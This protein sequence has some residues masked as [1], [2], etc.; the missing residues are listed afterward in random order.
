[1]ITNNKI[2]IIKLIMMLLTSVSICNCKINKV[3]NTESED[4]F[5]NDFNQEK[6]EINEIEVIKKTYE[7]KIYDENIKS[8]SIGNESIDVGEPMLTL[9]SNSAINISFDQIDEQI[10]NLQYEIIHCN[11][12][13]EESELLEM[14][15]LE[16]YKINYI[17]N[18]SKSFGTL[19]AYVHYEFKLPNENVTLTKSGNYIIRL[20]DE[21]DP[22]FSLATIKFFISENLMNV[23]FKVL[24]TS[25]FEQRNYQQEFE[26]TY[27]YDPNIVTDPYNNLLITLQQN[28]QEFNEIR[29][30]SPNFVR[31]NSIVYLANSD[32]VF[33]GGN[34]FRFF[35][36]S[37]FRKLSENV[38]KINYIDSTY[39]VQLIKEPKRSFK[40]YLSYKD[41]NGK[42]FL[43]S[44]DHENDEVQ[45]EYGWVNFH[46]NSKEIKSNDVYIFG[47]LSNWEINEKFKMS[48]DTINQEYFHKLFL[49]QGYY[50]YLFVTSNGTKISHRTLEG[51]HFETENEYIIKAYYRDPID[52][53]DRILSYRVFNSRN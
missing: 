33:D 37:S 46:L 31:E 17:E 10:N 25:N 32:K 39:Q 21:Y 20:F 52:L 40:Q 36:I 28:H 19:D 43:R 49:K 44:F 42:F 4:Y 8:L 6:E 13:W 45:S 23:N 22:E 12:N 16:G 18:I 38:K 47:Q 34:E 27:S 29:V 9:N 14:E 51:A 1:M 30:E 3:R 15:F 11:I 41:L 53:Y 7:N 35:D 48:Y 50:N 24:E 2:S 26:F 5:K